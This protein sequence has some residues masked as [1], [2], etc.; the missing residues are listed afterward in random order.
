MLT[1]FQRCRRAACQTTSWAICA[2]L[3]AS[4]FHCGIQAFMVESKC[5]TSASLLVASEENGPR[6]PGRLVSLPDKI[7]R[8]MCVCQWPAASLLCCPLH[9]Y[10]HA[11]VRTRNF[12]FSVTSRFILLTSLFYDKAGLGWQINLKC[13]ELLFMESHPGWS[14]QFLFQFLPFCAWRYDLAH[15]R[16]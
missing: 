6:L 9:S 13:K 14:D 12:Y 10:T 11:H 3:T 15:I 1:C 2:R 5:L 8:T 4:R 7:L 16:T